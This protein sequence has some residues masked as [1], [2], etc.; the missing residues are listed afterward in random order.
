MKRIMVFGD[1]HIPYVDKTAWALFL[2]AAKVFKPNVLVCLGD[3]VDCYSLAD[4]VRDPSRSALFKDEIGPANKC[5]DELDALNAAHKYYIAGNHEDR[6]TRLLHKSAPGLSKLVAIDG[7]LKLKERGWSYLP[8]GAYL[9]LGK[10]VFTHDTGR[11]G[12]HALAGAL[13]DACTNIVIGHVHFVGLKMEGAI[14]GT[15]R[16]AMSP[17]WLGDASKADYMHTL[18]ASRDWTQGFIYGY[19]RPDGAMHLVPAPLVRRTVLVAGSLI[20]L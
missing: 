13:H 7:L 14:D 19:V 5:L 11:A 12:P 15:A 2:A 4:Y 3:F 16:F 6:L 20:T 10:V 9:K 18:R 17:G 8:Y 1:P